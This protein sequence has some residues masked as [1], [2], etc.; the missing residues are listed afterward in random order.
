[1]P[2]LSIKITLRQNR[3]KITFIIFNEI[4][5][6]NPTFSEVKIN[7]ANEKKKKKP[8]WS[9]FSKRVEKSVLVNLGPSHPGD[10]GKGQKTLRRKRRLER[11]RQRGH[12][13]VRLYLN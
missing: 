11:E 3:N 12:I 5:K 13:R 7:K 8:Q 1:M 10:N 4:K 9:E 6:R 2:T